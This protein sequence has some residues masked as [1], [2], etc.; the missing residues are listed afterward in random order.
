MVDT[1]A[2][3]MIISQSTLHAVN[4]HL[5]QQGHELPPLE[6][7]TVRLYG[8]DE[9]KGGKELL[10]T[11]QVPLLL[12]LG[13][14]SVSVPVFVQPDSDQACLLGINGISVL[15]S[16]GKPVLSH[17]PS[18]LSEPEVATVSLVESLTLL[19]QKGR[20]LKAGVCSPV[21][22]CAD[23]LFEPNRDLLIHLGV[24]AYEYV[25]TANGDGEVLL[26]RIIGV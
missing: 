15:Q 8:K 11:A 18:S 1:G 6:L 7:P 21:P 19:S 3:S 24:S 4:Q 9:E 14:K 5:K 13:D 25:I 22:S 12:S 2:Q 17:V 10:I 26:F 16:D 23:L 20:M